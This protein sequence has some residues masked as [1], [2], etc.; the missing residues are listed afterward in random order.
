MLDFR[1]ESRDFLG[2]AGGW[3]LSRGSDKCELKLKVSKDGDEVLD[4]SREDQDLEKRLNEFSFWEEKSVSSN[5]VFVSDS[6]DILV[7]DEFVSFEY[8]KLWSGSVVSRPFGE[9]KD[10]SRE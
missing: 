3:S 8:S 4:L 9:G 10:L 7:G 6:L 5:E 1:E 2:M